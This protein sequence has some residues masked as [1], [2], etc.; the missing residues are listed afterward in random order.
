M[1][2]SLS[3]CLKLLKH[4]SSFFRTEGGRDCEWRIRLTLIAKN[5]FTYHVTSSTKSTFC[6]SNVH[7]VSSC[8]VQYNLYNAI[9][10]WPRSRL[11]EVLVIH[12]RR[13][14]TKSL[15]RLHCVISLSYIHRHELYVLPTL[16]VH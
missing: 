2:T 6:C 13:E 4:P 16:F 9:I 8:P 3:N 1:S 7:L 10:F 15:F 14:L 12:L 5:C 11:L